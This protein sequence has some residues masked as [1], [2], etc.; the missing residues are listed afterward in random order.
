MCKY[1]C[2]AL[3]LLLSQN[4][5]HL[6]D[7]FFKIYENSESFEVERGHLRHGDVKGV[8][9]L[10]HFVLILGIEFAFVFLNWHI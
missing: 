2:L 6:M 1:C 5:V 7:E 4:S 3:S 10:R 9:V 8:N